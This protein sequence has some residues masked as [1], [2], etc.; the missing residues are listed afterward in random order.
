M[1]SSILLPEDIDVGKMYSAGELEASIQ[2]K[3][4]PSALYIMLQVV[5]AGRAIYHRNG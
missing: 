2:K 5:D 4:T 1:H 3:G